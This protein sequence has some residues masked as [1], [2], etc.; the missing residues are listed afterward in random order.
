MTRIDQVAKASGVSISTVSY[1]FSGKRPVAEDTRK[2]IEQVAK[3]LGYSPNAGARM[4]AGRMTHIFAVSEPLHEHTHAPTHMAFVLATSLAARKGGWDI[5]LLTDREASRGMERVARSRLVDAILVL[6]VA[7]DD[8]RVALA[9]ELSIPV[10][11]VGIPDDMDGLVCVDLDFEGATRLAV[12]KLVESGHSRI[13]L[14]GHPRI[15]YTTSNFPR[16][17]R[18]AFLRHAQDR[19]VSGS[20]FELE[21]VGDKA[22]QVQSAVDNALEA[23]ATGFVLHNGQNAHEL[24]L[25]DLESRGLSVPKDIS[26]VS[27]GAAFD[28][29]A[30]GTPISAIPLIADESCGVA[31]SLALESVSTG[32]VDPGI[33]LV[34]PT[35]IDNHSIVQAARVR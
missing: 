28:T 34:P 5:L 33:V 32:K 9:R 10:V 31:V 20:F 2:R 29:T 35:F 3:E 24:L 7:P 15:S 17:V 21:G 25:R 4:L 6:D 18:D 13:A 1:A 8:E 11:F 22:D 26:L 27:V 30:L 12:D 16:R 14:I 23:G 19:G